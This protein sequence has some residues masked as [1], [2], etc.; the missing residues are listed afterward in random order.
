LGHRVLKKN[1]LAFG[2]FDIAFTSWRKDINC[3]MAGIDILLM[4]SLNEGTPVAILEAM[5]AA[6][7]I[8]STPVGGITELIKAA[9]CGFVSLEKNEMVK[10]VELLASSDEL[11]E[12]K[13]LQ[14][15]QFVTENLTIERQS[16]EVAKFY[17]KRL[18]RT[19][20]A[21]YQ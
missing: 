19:Q 17:L 10:Q 16:E 8:V 13:G 3:V 20:R 21:A 7:P 18:Q 1:S 6:K 5:A 12:E 14:G 4:T 2:E 15:R 9:D 11:R